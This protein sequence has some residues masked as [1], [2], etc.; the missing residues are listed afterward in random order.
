M[1]FRDGA[2]N[3]GDLLG[4]D[5]SHWSFFFD[6]D[7]SNMEGNDIADNGN[8]TFRTVGAVSQYC[9]LDQYAMGLR[10]PSEVAPMFVV[11]GANGAAEDPPRIGVDLR[12]TRKEV[13]I[14][15]VIAAMGP[16]VPSAATAQKNFR[17]A[18][19]YVVTGARES[20]D[21]L[22]KL[23]RIRSGWETYF[24]DSVGGR[25]SMNARLR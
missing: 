18:F 3:S 9:A 1:E 6:S 24:S 8:G 11:R 13:R 20:S 14:E 5:Q 7:A 15:D 2:S 22:A 17:D 21:E 16:R 12:G 19:I 10:L 25:G 4:R 23:E